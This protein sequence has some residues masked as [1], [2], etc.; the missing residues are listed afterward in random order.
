MPFLALN[1][2]IRSRYQNTT[3]YSFECT[4]VLCS[5][6]TASD[7]YAPLCAA[8]GVDHEKESITAGDRPIGLVDDGGVP[9]RQL[10][11]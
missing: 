1:L 7:L 5:D 4:A 6:K 10:L 8:L 3:Q 11:A 2:L 9:I